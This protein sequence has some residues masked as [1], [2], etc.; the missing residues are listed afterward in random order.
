MANHYLVISVGTYGD[1]YPFMCIARALQT[2]GRSVTFISHS[3]YAS[4]AKEAA[5]PFI[6]VGTDED[7]FHV[8]NNPDL[9][10]PIK[11]FD[12]IFEKYGEGTSQILDA[13]HAR[14][15]TTPPVVIAHPFAIP[16]AT[17]ARDTGF[18]S[19]V[20]GAFLAPSNFKSVYDPLTLGPTP[21]P[22]WVPL[23]WRRALWRFVE[24]R[25]LDP[26]T[27]P[28][29]NAIRTRHGLPALT[30][31]LGQMADSPDLTLTLFPSWFG[32]VKPDW[33]SPLLQGDFQ[34]FDVRKEQEFSP[35]LDAFL[36]AG[37]KPIVFTP[38]SG[39]LHAHRFFECALQ[40]ITRIGKRAIF[41]T[42]ERSQ[43]PVSL[44]NNILWQAYVPL[45]RLLPFADIFVH[46]GGIGSTAEALRAGIAQVI[47]PYAWDQFDNGERI[48]ALHAGRV[49]P[50]K[51]LRA[52]PL[53]N[54]LH[55]L[56][57][58]RNARAQ[59]TLLAA[60]F[61]SSQDASALCL[62]MEAK[63]GS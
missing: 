36:N 53:A 47:T 20:V 30:S 32:P 63:L 6:G 31:F 7:Y 26:V 52:K 23:S 2:L 11:G 29:L 51:R 3:Y 60:R 62:Q 21:I 15:S 22:P 27:M 4:L 46:H 1:I 45:A 61:S 28:Q 9:W 48:S 18:V 35:E 24:K 37:D 38:G 44:P 25:Y 39:N 19:A 16:A 8:L 40:A 42:R 14:A 57:A 54:A 12:A 43:I 34:L 50:A 17:I 49:L 33:P 59:C 58:D 10:D 55:A 56:S 41:L 13:I 5:L